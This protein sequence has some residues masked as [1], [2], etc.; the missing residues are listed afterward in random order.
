MSVVLRCPT[1]E[2]VRAICP[3]LSAGKTDA[4]LDDIARRAYAIARVLWENAGLLP[5]TAKASSLTV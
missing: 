2:M 1:P 5:T 3:K 4:E